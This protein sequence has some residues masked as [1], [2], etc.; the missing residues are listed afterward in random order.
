MIQKIAAADLNHLLVKSAHVIRTQGAEIQELKQHLAD[1]NRLDHA[2]KI[3]SIAVDRGIMSEDNATEYASKLAE[4]DRD[5]SMVEDFVSRNSGA[6]L[7][8][9]NE[10]SKTASDDPM[11]DGET[12]E[13]RFSNFILTL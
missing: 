9:G 10:M 4:S 7:P 13:G 2:E 1:K 8:L 11:A 12:A 6:G 3:A 5:L